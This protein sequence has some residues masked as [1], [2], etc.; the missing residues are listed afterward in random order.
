MEDVRLAALEILHVRLAVTKL[1]DCKKISYGHF[2]EKKSAKE[3]SV[4]FVNHS[5]PGLH[6]LRLLGHLSSVIPN[7]NIRWNVVLLKM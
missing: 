2:I 7:R 5:N 3:Y 6:V 1:D 4:V